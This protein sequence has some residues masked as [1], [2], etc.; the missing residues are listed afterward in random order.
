MSDS[1]QEYKIPKD[2]QQSIIE[3]GREVQVAR[4]AVDTANK[5]HYDA[6]EILWKLVHA[7]I[8]ELDGKENLVL[9]H[10]TMVVKVRDE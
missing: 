5:G 6:V 7:A 9:D 1:K 3:A 8:P 4:L 2:W 10:K